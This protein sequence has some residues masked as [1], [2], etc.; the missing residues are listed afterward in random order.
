MNAVPRRKKITVRFT[1]EE[2]FAVR[3]AAFGRGL[4]MGVLLHK[5]IKPMI[6]G[7]TLTEPPEEDPD[8]RHQDK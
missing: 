2:Y 7:G 3:N 8:D 5:K 6:D 4:D 1:D